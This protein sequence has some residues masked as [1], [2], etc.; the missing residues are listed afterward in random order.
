MKQPLVSIIIA[1]YNW[2]D[3]WFTQTVNSILNQTY[4]NIELI[5]V[6]DA[7]TNNI[8]EVI[9]RYCKQYDN[10]I[11]L[12]NEK[13]CERSYSR[14][15]WIFESKWKYIAFCD[16]DDV[17]KDRDKIEKQV[18]FLEKNKDYVL[19][20]T[21]IIEVDEDN[22]EIKKIEV[23]NWNNSIKNLLLQSN[24]FALSSVMIRKE[25]LLFS[26]LFN[27]GY[28]TVEDY[29]LWLRIWRYW[30]ID[31][32]SNSFIYYRTWRWNTSTTFKSEMRKK[33]FWSMWDNKHYYPN[34]LKAFIMRL[35]GLVLPEK[36][37]IIIP[38]IL[39]FK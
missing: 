20:W 15:R 1:T 10:I 22:E 23:I 28:N 21:S 3:K 14:N 32:I 4:K 11:Y 16:D 2:K 29:D 8:E 31:N 13:N 6:N 27:S 35:W 30:K 39:K 9:L 34:F 25:V 37:K 7:S 5:I 36:I 18:E 24:Q 12:K 33:C 19:C 38:K 26:G 17:W